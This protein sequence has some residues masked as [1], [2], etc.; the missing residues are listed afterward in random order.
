MTIKV[1]MANVIQE[2]KVNMVMT[3]K[4]DA[5]KLLQHCVESGIQY[6]YRRAHKHTDEPGEDVIKEQIER[7]IMGELCDWFKFDEDRQP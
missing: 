6:G 2:T 5:Y 1:D 7:A 4:V 3:A